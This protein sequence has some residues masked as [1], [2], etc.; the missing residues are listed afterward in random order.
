MPSEEKVVHRQKARL[1]VLDGV[2]WE[3]RG[4]GDLKLIKNRRTGE[5]RLEMRGTQYGEVCLSQLLSQQV[6]NCFVKTG[7]TAW[8]WRDPRMREQYQLTLDTQRDSEKFKKKL[9]ENSGTRTL[10]GFIQNFSAWYWN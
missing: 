7:A 5:L 10:L 2:G 9:D 6:L 1:S 4:R 8:R 3:E